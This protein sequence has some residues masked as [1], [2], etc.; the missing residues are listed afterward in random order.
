MFQGRVV[1]HIVCDLC[2]TWAPGIFDSRE[3]AKSEAIRIG[4]L[5]DLPDNGHTGG[6]W[7]D[8]CIDCGTWEQ[9]WPR[10]DCAMWLVAC[11]TCQAS[12]EEFNCDFP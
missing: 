7:D 3:E 5:A 2:G 8:L 1:H 4:W 9:F 10:V 6:K 12:M 11:K